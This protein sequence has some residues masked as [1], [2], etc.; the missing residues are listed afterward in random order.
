ML[1]NDKS[2][3]NLIGVLVSRKIPTMPKFKVII[4]D[5]ETGKAESREL[6]GNQAAPFLSRKINDTIDGSTVGLPKRDILITGGCD[7]GSHDH[8]TQGSARVWEVATGWE[9]ART[10][11]DDT[12]NG[13]AF[14]PDGQYVTSGSRDGIT[15]VW[16]VAT[17]QEVARWL[18]E[19]WVSFV[20][21]SPDG[22]YVV[23]GG[24]EQG[25]LDKLVGFIC[26][27]GTV[28]VWETAAWRQV[29]R[30]TYEDDV[31]KQ[32]VKEIAFSSDGKHVVWRVSNLA[33]VSEMA[34]GRRVAQMTHDRTVATVGFS[35]D[36]KYVISGGCDNRDSYP[37]CSQGNARVWEVATSQEV[38]RMIDVHG[39]WGLTFS[40]EGRYVIS[41]GGGDIRTWEVGTGE[42]VFRMHHGDWVE[43]VAFSPDG[44]YMISGGC[45][46]RASLV[47]CDQGSARVWEVATGQAVSGM[48]HDD[49]VNSVA[50][51]PDGKYIVSGSF[52][53]TV[54]VWEAATGREISWMSHRRGHLANVAFSPDGKYVVV[55][56]GG[57]EV[58]VWLYRPEDLITEAC[59]RNLT[60]AQWNQYLDNVP[61]R[62]GCEDL[63]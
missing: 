30:M 20:A 44:K 35:P 1:I 32:D 10:I 49:E 7:I 11:H 47:D 5:P 34:T 21:F 36:G 62:R 27:Q 48:S 9:V 41:V 24:C 6:E 40:S 22:N 37:D 16:E 14:S 52:D 51:S 4:S 15:R 17:G 12:V 58:R 23:S 59:T 61:Y 45:D 28:R 46:N 43:V 2:F 18:H 13:V 60:E 19:S 56:V 57:G 33:R 26:Y 63:P 54:R 42:E 29:T 3:C 55:V 25:E 39:M 38:A 31:N 8:C 50:F 53:G